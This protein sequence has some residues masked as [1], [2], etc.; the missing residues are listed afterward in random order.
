MLREVLEAYRRLQEPSEG[1]KVVVVDN[2]STD[3]TANV[4]A[5]FKN[6]LPLETISEPKSG[7]N[8]ALNTGLKL[9]EGDLAVFTDDDAFPTADWLVRMRDVANAEPLYSIFGG[10]VLPR[11][12][13]TPPAW[14]RRVLASSEPQGKKTYE[15]WMGPVYTL[16]DP[17]LE[18][19]P[20]RPW[21]VFGPNMAIRTSIFKSGVRF[22]QA[23][24]PRGSSYPMGS[25][26]EILLRLSRQGHRAWFIKEAIVE[27]FVRKEQLQESWVLR[28]GFRFGRGAQRL[29]PNRKQ[30]MSILGSFVWNIPKEALF[31]AA[32]SVLFRPDAAFRAHWRFNYLRGRAYEAL[33]MERAQRAGTIPPFS[34]YVL[35]R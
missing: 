3:E 14:I 20:V 12:E 24:G 4:L 1:W 2:G 19:G 32:A 27:H 16:T 22:D 29:E 8:Q 21:L 26:T 5:S 10:T 33:L 18:D 13:M 17:S 28:R 9:L 7:K 31:M 25:E 15:A 23:V 6:L 35:R 34:K 11:W 30:W